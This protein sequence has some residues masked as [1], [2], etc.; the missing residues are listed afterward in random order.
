MH[1]MAARFSLLAPGWDM[2]LAAF[3][4][5]IADATKAEGV[6]MMTPDDVLWAFDWGFQGYVD[7]DE[8]SAAADALAAALAGGDLEDEVA[9]VIVSSVGGPFVPVRRMRLS[10]FSVIRSAFHA[11]QGA[12]EPDL[13]RVFRVPDRRP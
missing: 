11:A 6:H 10:E 2:T 5:A 1:I 9:S 12:E 4:E 13:G 8:V 3:Q 7:S